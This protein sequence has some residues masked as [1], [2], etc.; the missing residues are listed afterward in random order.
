M[1]DQ[2]PCIQVGASGVDALGAAGPGSLAQAQPSVPGRAASGPRGGASALVPGLLACVGIAI[3]SPALAAIAAKTG[4]RLNAQTIALAAGML[5]ANFAPARLLLLAEG[6]AFSR[7]H[8]LRVAIV[9][10]GLQIT[11]QSLVGAGLRVVVVDALMLTSTFALAWYLGNRLFGLDR[12]TTILVG[13]GAA[14]CGASAVLATQQVLDAKTE[15]TTVALATVVLFGSVSF[16]LYPLLAELNASL[17]LIHGGAAGFGRYIGST[18]H[19]VAQVVAT[20]KALGQQAVEVAVVSKMARVA[21]LVPFLMV[22][23]ACCAHLPRQGAIEGQGTDHDAAPVFSRSFL[24]VLPLFPFVFLLAVA[25]NSLG[26]MPEPARESIKTF[27]GYLLSAAMAGAGFGT[28]FSVVR[29]AGRKPLLMALVLFLW[30]VVGGALIN[31]VAE[32]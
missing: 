5:A 13:A 25:I 28:R 9:L 14:I 8:I 6:A 3:A 26:V 2:Q 15:H 21:M 27:N 32:Y 18:V 17:N 4:L 1:N 23:A 10:F 30:L 11:V 7:T 22:V 29:K 31:A 20:G 16:A 19:E 24:H 12:N